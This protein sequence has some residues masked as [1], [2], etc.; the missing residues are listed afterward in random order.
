MLHLKHRANKFLFELCIEMTSA[1]KRITVEFNS[2]PGSRCK[3][4]LKIVELLNN[5]TPDSVL[6]AISQMCL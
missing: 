5:F 4:I 1:L 6:E 3:T 2:K